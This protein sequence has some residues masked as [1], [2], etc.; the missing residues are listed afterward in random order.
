MHLISHFEWYVLIHGNISEIF[1]S[2]RNFENIMYAIVFSN[3]PADI[4]LALY[5]FGTSGLNHI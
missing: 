2:Q 1:Y 5:D 3:M 4:P